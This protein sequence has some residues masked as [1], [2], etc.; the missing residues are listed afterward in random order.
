MWNISSI[1]VSW[2]Q[3]TEDVYTWNYIQDY[4]DKSS[5][6][7]E[8]R[9]TCK[10][11]LNLKEKLVKCY[12]WSMALHGA[13]TWT[14]QKVDQKYLESFEM[15]G[16]RRMEKISGTDRVRSKEVLNSV[17]GERNSLH[18]IRSGKTNWMGHIFG[19]N[20]FLNHIIDGKLEIISDGKTRM[21]T[22]AGRR[23]H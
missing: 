16:W 23:K 21:K 10:L 22:W 20:C 7:Q 14:L 4:H 12:I 3:T 9:F 13:E 8:Q 2:K 18:M 1:W 6:P 15:M 11:H 5:I 19:R 17:K